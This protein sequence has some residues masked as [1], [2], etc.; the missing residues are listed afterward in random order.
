MT[1]EPVILLL[2]PPGTREDDRLLLEHTLSEFT[3]CHA[4]ERSEFAK[5]LRENHCACILIGPLAA[6]DSAREMIA[7]VRGS[8]SE[9][10][11]VVIAE[12]SDEVAIVE[13]LKLGASDWISRPHL[14]RLNVAVATALD[15]ATHGAPS[16]EPNPDLVPTSSDAG[17]ALGTG[18]EVDH[19]SDRQRSPSTVANV[20]SLTNIGSCDVTMEAGVNA[21]HWSENLYRMLG[22]DPNT[23]P[24]SKDSWL[25]S[26]HPQDRE[27][28][29]TSFEKLLETH[30]A[31]DEEYRISCPDGT[32]KTVRTRGNFT[33]D[34]A[35][36]ACR[37]T[38]IT[39]DVT[40]IRRAEAVSKGLSST[41]DLAGDAIFMYDP[42]D[43]KFFY[44][45]RQA[46]IS[47]GYSRD[48]LYEMTP[49]DIDPTLNPEISK[50]RV[51]KLKVKP[52][53]IFIFEGKIQR[54]DGDVVP[55]ELQTRYV[56]PDGESP[57][58]VVIARDLSERHAAEA[59]LRSFKTTLDLTNDGVIIYDAENFEITYVN[60][61]ILSQ[62]GYSESELLGQQCIVL[63]PGLNASMLH[64][65]LAPLVGGDTESHLGRGHHLGKDGRNVPVEVM[66][67][68]VAPTG[69]RPRFVSFTRDIS[70]RL[71][72]EQERDAAE[73]RWKFALE[74]ANAGVWDYDLETEEI[75]YSPQWK[76][77]LGFA[78]DEIEPT[79]R[80]WR[81]LIEPD[82]V[83][84]IDREFRRYI[85]GDIRQFSVEC[86]VRRKDGNT[87][88]TLIAGI[89]V[90]RDSEGRPTR[91]IGTQTDISERKHIESQ[92]LA[93]KEEAERAS[94]VKSQF[95]SRVSHEL[96]TP[97]NSIIGFN[98]LMEMDPDLN[99]NHQTFVGEIRS[100][101][102]HLLALIDDVLDLSR[103]ESQEILWSIED[104]NL[105]EITNECI[106]L[107]NPA[108]LSNDLTI[109]FDC[110]GNKAVWAKADRVR[111]KQV[112]VNFLTNAIKYNRPNGTITVT[113]ATAADDMV[114]LIVK[115]TGLGIA[116]ENIKQ[117]FEP[118]T[119]ITTE[120]V[121][122][123]GTGIGLAIARSLVE[124][125][126]GRIRVESELGVGSKFT[127]ELPAGE[128][129]LSAQNLDSEVPDRA[130][131]TKSNNACK[132]LY[133]DDN[134][135]NLALVEG[136]VSKLRPQWSLTTTLDP[137]DGIDLALSGE[138]DAFLIDMQ[139]E[140]TDGYEI[141][142]KIKESDKIVDAPAIALS[143][144][145]M[146]SD[147][148]VALK[149]GFTNYIT[150]PI[151]I[152]MFLEVLDDLLL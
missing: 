4:S 55:V 128:D 31:F 85:N 82:D 96:R 77:I 23:T 75:Y 38:G 100:A 142:H 10:P 40:A 49:P 129:A 101:S 20:E 33:S 140:D 122:V 39:D 143:A 5:R 127:A 116:R 6:G 106:A 91:F 59:S 79:P 70:E 50:D 125:M 135:S 27:R 73:S 19:G 123:E 87:I 7:M 76:S 147:I 16:G 83:A 88:W 60:Q 146:Q 104:V 48:E 18:T 28:I 131:P 144:N 132:V 103:I 109:E 119:R 63:E 12:N 3:V 35:G 36:Q 1:T 110:Q 112:L 108:A 99:D 57:R 90:A 111:I 136:I 32:T 120:G 44:V 58:M 84:L 92:L 102:N 43:L 2:S 97:M 52:E 17:T 68:Y 141:L 114:Q 66:T 72:M 11:I 118:F 15:G 46:E 137:D 8:S 14:A 98:Q 95:L 130:L 24:A 41:L 150:K 121:T 134:E 113:L 54:K 148:D 64:D 42:V 67:Q 105:V 45:N 21:M 62:T 30:T 152:E 145:A 37:I 107:S 25:N 74:G 93:A 47:T 86:R 53:S 115:D 13:A 89:I 26:I 71:V 80:A 124:G 51:G 61:A 9:L 56:K 117:I 138:Y 126:G 22:L 34:G 29:A 151:N 94:Q 69:E 139:F 81:V 149:S 65:E 133:I 78:E